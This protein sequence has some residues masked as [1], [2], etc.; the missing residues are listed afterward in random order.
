MEWLRRQLAYWANRCG[1]CEAAG[2]PDSGHSVRQCWRAESTAVKQT[3]EKW[4]K[5][6]VFDKWS[7]CFP[8][9]GVPQEICNSWE[10][11][12]AGKYQRVEGGECQYKGVLSAGLLGIAMGCEDV[13][14]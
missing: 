8:C 2:E 12:G 14:S 6:I 1:L 7:G 4:D 5:G 3:V 9:G 10:P 13:S 11:N